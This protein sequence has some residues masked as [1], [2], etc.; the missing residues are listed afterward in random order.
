[1]H[2]GR[3]VRQKR[4]EHSSRDFVLRTLSR[5]P[6]LT[7][8]FNFYGCF[9]LTNAQFFILPSILYA[10]PQHQ[11]QPGIGHALILYVSPIIFIYH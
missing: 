6:T 2:S 3:R 7:E 1:M 11:S 4:K 9:M 5:S 10:I 8:A